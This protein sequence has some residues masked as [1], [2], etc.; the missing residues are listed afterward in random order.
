MKKE[1]AFLQ[2]L[3]IRSTG[4]IEVVELD[5]IQWFS[6]AGNYVELH[7]NQ[8]TLLHRQPLSQLEKRLDP[9]FIL[10]VHRSALVRRDQMSVLSVTG[11]GTYEL[12]LRNGENVAVSERYVNSVR[13]AMKG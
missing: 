2:K 11:D 5:Q 10:R 13:E 1:P 12:G 7:M 3:T 8:K 4:K 6:S 9:N